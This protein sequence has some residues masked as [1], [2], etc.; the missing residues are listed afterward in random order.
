ME[1]VIKLDLKNKAVFQYYN[2]CLSRKIKEVCS[3]IGFSYNGITWIIF[4]PD[5][6]DRY[7]DTL[8]QIQ[9]IIVGRQG[10][11]YGFCNGIDTI[12]ISTLSIEKECCTNRIINKRL[13]KSLGFSTYSNDDLL[14][15][16]ILDELAHIATGCD[17]GTLKYDKTLEK[18]QQAYYGN[19]LGLRGYQL[20][21]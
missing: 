17:H 16:V 1:P 8:S 12:W 5:A 2:E 6:S 3:K 19:P 10:C 9:K 21:L 4:D 14:A 18:F 15:D 11:D 7:C 20:H 13:I